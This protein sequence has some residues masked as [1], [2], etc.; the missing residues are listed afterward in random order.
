MKT[1]GISIFTPGS[2]LPVSYFDNH[3]ELLNKAKDIMEK[4]NLWFVDALTETTNKGV[5]SAV[6]FMGPGKTIQLW[7]YHPLRSTFAHVYDL[8]IDH[9]FSVKPN[10]EQSIASLKRLI[11]T[12]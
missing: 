11:D 1:S 7:N 12:L 6:V 2:N 4:H 10:I 5:I 3:S 9:V 8:N